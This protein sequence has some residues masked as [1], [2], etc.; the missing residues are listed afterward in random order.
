M[1]IRQIEAGL[2]HLTVVDENE[3]PQPTGL[4]S[5]VGCVSTSMDDADDRAADDST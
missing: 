3:A 4:K 2:K 5:K 1:T